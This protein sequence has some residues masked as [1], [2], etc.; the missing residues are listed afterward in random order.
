MKKENGIGCYISKNLI[1][2]PMEYLKSHSSR[3]ERKTT[4]YCLACR[5]RFLQET[6]FR[7]FER[8]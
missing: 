8:K 2:V 6:P 4:S 5:D 7:G 3:K 1:F